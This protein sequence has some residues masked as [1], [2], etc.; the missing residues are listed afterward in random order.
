LEWNRKEKRAGANCWGHT[1]PGKGT[2]VVRGV[3][4][5]ILLVFICM[6][7]E[8]IIFAQ[9]SMAKMAPRGDEFMAES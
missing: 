9:F 1:D 6:L 3:I 7:E 4:T 5:C 2:V 8:L